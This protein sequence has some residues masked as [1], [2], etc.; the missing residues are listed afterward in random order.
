MTGARRTAAPDR[1]R[2]A[3][4]AAARCRQ[5]QSRPPRCGCRRR[6]FGDGRRLDDAVAAARSRQARLGA[7][8]DPR[9]R[10]D[11]ARRRRG[12]R[13]QCRGTGASSWRSR[14]ARPKPRVSARCAAPRRS[15]A[16]TATRA[17]GQAGE[18]FASPRAGEQILVTR[19]P[20]GVVAV[21][22][23]FN[24]PIAIPAWKIAPALVYGNT[25]VWKPASTVPLLAIRL[26]DALRDS[27]PA[28]RRA[29]PGRRRR[30]RSATRWSTTDG[31]DAITFTG[32]TGVGP[33]DRRRGGGARRA[34]AG[35]DGRQERRRGSRRRRFRPGARAGHAGRIPLHR[36]E[37]HRHFTID[38]HRRDRRPLPGSAG[39][40][41]PRRWSSA[42][43]P[44][45]RRRWVR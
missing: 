41:G 25:V 34:G 2:V 21:I 30:R 24:F 14:R 18:I 45:T 20:I 44:T 1:R 33:A 10:R 19:K 15:C 37:V 16:T 3:R 13:P 43:P 36:P 23:P 5:R 29:Q 27:G 12:G 31:I 35:R 38:R 28:R 4:A 17:T 40:T 6:R 32:S 39:R 42:I 9:A 8:P 11:P 22:T 7:H 26:A